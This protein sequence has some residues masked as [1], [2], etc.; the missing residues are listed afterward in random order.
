MKQI[1]PEEFVTFFQSMKSQMEPPEN[2]HS[3][4]W[5]ND[6]KVQR[7]LGDLIT[8]AII[9]VGIDPISC[10]LSAIVT[11]FQLGRAFELA[12]IEQAELE[13]LNQQ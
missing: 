8:G 3:N 12:K 10:M 6:I 1:T 7:E 4:Y 11:G 9:K 13:R 5:V 2:Y